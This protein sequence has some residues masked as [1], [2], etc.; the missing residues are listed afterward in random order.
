MASMLDTL[1]DDIG[2]H[3]DHVAAVEGNSNS[4]SSRTEDWVSATW[5]SWDW[6]WRYRPNRSHDSWS[7]SYGGT[8]AV[9]TSVPAAEPQ[10]GVATSTAGN[11]S[12]AD[13][14]TTND[15]WGS[16]GTSSQVQD[17]PGQTGTENTGQT[18]ADSWTWNWDS[19]HSW[20]WSQRDWRQDGWQSGQWDSSQPKPDYTDPPSW[21]GWS[22][23]RL[24]T[25]AIRRWNKQTD[26]PM[27]RRAEKVLR[28]LGW[29][30][31]VDME[32][33]SDEVLG[34]SLYLEAIIE[35]LN[36]KAGVRED[37]DRRRA[38]R[39]AIS[40]SQRHKD[41]TLAQFAVRRQRDFR[42][43]AAHGVQ[44][45]EALRAMLM[46]EGAGLTDQNQQNLTALLQGREEDPD[47]VARALSR[48]DVRHDRIAAFSEDV[49]EEHSFLAAD[50]NDLDDEDEALEES[51]VIQELD[52][53]DL[54][55]DQVC[56]VFAVLEQRRRTWKEN[57]VLKADMRKD[58]GN[59]IKDGAN[60]APRGQYG[61]VPGG[62]IPGSGGAPRHGGRGGMNRE[63]LKKISRCRLC[64]KRGHGGE[65]CN[66]KKK[67]SPS[68]FSYCGGEASGSSA[69]SFLTLQELRSAITA[70]RL[71]GGSMESDST[72][73]AFLAIP[74][75][76]AILDIGATQDLI[77]SEAF[78]NLSQALSGV[79]LQ[80]V[81]VDKAVSV[82]SG[83]GGVAKPKFVALVPISPGGIP[84][85]LEMTVLEDRIPPL[86]SVGFLEFLQARI[87]LPENKISLQKLE[88]ELPMQRLPT[89]HR[90][91]NIVQWKGGSFPV[92]IEVQRKYGI[93]DGAFN[94]PNDVPCAYTKA[95]LCFEGV[96]TNQGISNEP[97]FNTPFPEFS[98]VLLVNHGF[99]RDDF[100]ADRNLSCREV[101]PG[102]GLGKVDF[103]FVAQH[104][105]HCMWHEHSHEHP[106]RRHHQHPHDH[107]LHHGTQP[108]EG[109]GKVEIES[110]MGVSNSH[111][112]FDTQLTRHGARLSVKPRVQL[113]DDGTQL[114]SPVAQVDAGD[115][116][117]VGGQSPQL[118]AAGQGGAPHQEL[119]HFA[120]ASPCGACCS[121][122]PSPGGADHQ[123]L[124][125]I[126]ELEGVR[127]VF[128]S[129]AIPVEEIQCE[130]QGKGASIGTSISLL[131]ACNQCTRQL[132]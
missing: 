99:L 93:S 119:P 115:D 82:P 79:G 131:R 37:D 130:G 6:S 104:G 75:T 120:T 11:Q 22:H 111:P 88:I 47:A 20:Q 61:G 73:C 107:P 2:N 77:G 45:P 63:Q 32:H 15:P 46:R 35:V 91:I 38:Y 129:S 5:Q 121:P 48:M 53:L 69:F 14:L 4:T 52:K 128:S 55:E 60:A 59:F 67:P 122:M 81:R 74:G 3:A 41:E 29:D 117:G 21:P 72:G 65:D 58:R 124:K 66:L 106:L 71:D 102:G 16:A 13:P 40:D 17:Q 108:G 25:L 80:P 44:I 8:Y 90:S 70:V 132:L 49:P 68:G 113:R 1:D 30:L 39:A 42:N 86:L 31:Q 57:K 9:V 97:I 26:V 50:S 94:M 27:Y 105:N 127:Q 98:E 7:S 12:G 36:N 126:C 28:S 19:G 43:A 87:S 95:A 78:S 110:H 118:C 123:P 10:N 76:E 54:S 84:G 56:E 100:G 109:L 34:S 125:P 51:E 18:Q 116:V 112:Q 33:L 103:D 24:W 64:G 92:P 114:P 85:V 89:G 83:I 23:R 62:G 96:D 101:E